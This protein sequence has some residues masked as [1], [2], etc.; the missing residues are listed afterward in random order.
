[1]TVQNTV[2][3][4]KYITNGF[5][6]IYTLSY[7]VEDKDNLLI[8][9][10]DTVVSKNEYSYIKS[11]NAVQFNT[12]LS[13]NQKL[14]IFRKTQLERTT[15]YESFNNTFRPEVL[16]HDLDKI[17]LNLQE[18][19]HKVDQ[20]DLNYEYVVHTSTQALTEVV[21]AQ[22]RADQAYALANLT[23]TETRSIERGGTGAIDKATARSN[24][25]IYSQTETNN[26]L[27]TKLTANNNL[28]DLQDIA[29]ARTNL[30][31][32]NKAEV[33]ALVQT[34]GTGT[35]LTVEGGGTGA[36]TATEARTNLDVYSK[37]EV[38]EAITTSVP[39]VADATTTDKGIVRLATESDITNSSE[40]VALTPKNVSDMLIGVGASAKGFRALFSARLTELVG[41]NTS[42]AKTITATIA[43]HGL[44][45]GDVIRVSYRFA[46][47]TSNQQATDTVTVTSVTNANTFVFTSP[48]TLA[49]GSS[50]GGTCTLLYVIKNNYNIDSLT[51]NAVGRYTIA[52]NTASGITG[53]SFIPFV[54]AST[55]DNSVILPQ[56][57]VIASATSLTVRTFDKSG[58]AITP[59]WLHIGVTQ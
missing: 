59:Q 34:G 13:A 25:E 5:D 19:N 37:E 42:S 44:A 57:E 31:V 36:T 22:A 35:T 10:D 21:T 6:S 39:I 15:N 50:T 49:T 24:L 33:L 28:S 2:P 12:T 18:Q 48:Q 1:M 11:S 3:Y 17:W 55:A 58:V 26:L 43:S 23:N 29:I 4:E 32:H 45:V 40:D 8:K 20:Y 27:N 38:D 52:I 41:T 7:Y 9:L 54:S 46:F 14:E 16:N 53:T 30:D 56:P 47:I 51:I